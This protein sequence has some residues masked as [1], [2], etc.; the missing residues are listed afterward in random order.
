MKPNNYQ[1]VLSNIREVEA[2]SAKLNQYVI[3]DLAL[4]M[5]RAKKSY[6]TAQAL[7]LESWKDKSGDKLVERIVLLENSV[8]E[9]YIFLEVNLR[10]ELKAL[11]VQEL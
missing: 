5:K 8:R 2:S 10:D 9:L 6:D 4:R 3:E 7:Q 11:N 1:E